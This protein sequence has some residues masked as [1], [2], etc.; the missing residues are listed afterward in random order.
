MPAIARTELSTD[1]L[2]CSSRSASSPCS[3]SAA[4]A[5]SVVGDAAFAAAVA[6]ATAGAAVGGV[7]DGA[8]RRCSAAVDSEFGEV[9]ASGGDGGGRHSVEVEGGFVGEFSAFW[10]L[11]RS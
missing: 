3:R 11:E 7:A 5:T 4:A 9:V 8:D 6:A 10:S 1:S 2:L